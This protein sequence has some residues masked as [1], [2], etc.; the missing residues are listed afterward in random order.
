MSERRAVADP[1]DRAAHLRAVVDLARAG[2]LDTR[3]QALL[4]AHAALEGGDAEAAWW[5]LDVED[6]R[7][8]YGG[9]IGVELPSVDVIAGWDKSQEPWDD[10]ITA[11]GIV[12]G[13]RVDMSRRSIWNALRWCGKLTTAEEAIAEPP[14]SRD[15]SIG[16]APEIAS[17]LARVADRHRGL[18]A[19]G[20]A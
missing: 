8:I 5:A 9:W 16:L 15:L 1:E 10:E 11:C 3:E 18:F 19:G 12:C 2:V 6:R 13:V 17:R 20:G 4:G 7:E 14:A